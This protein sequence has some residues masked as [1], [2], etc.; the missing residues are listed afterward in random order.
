[1]RQQ[2]C[3]TTSTRNTGRSAAFTLVETSC[4]VGAL[5]IFV[6]AVIPSM[7]QL[8]GD[9]WAAVTRDHMRSY[10]T[11]HAAHIH[12]HGYLPPFALSDGYYPPGEPGNARATEVGLFDSPV[13]P[14]GSTSLI[15]LM[16]A[17]FEQYVHDPV[18]YTSP[19]DTL[20]RYSPVGGEDSF[21]GRFGY[22]LTPDED[23]RG[24]GA[25]FTRLWFTA[26]NWPPGYLTHNRT[27]V[28]EVDGLQEIREVS[29]QSIDRILSPADHVD[30]V[31]EDEMSRL[32]QSLFVPEQGAWAPPP[33][34]PGNSNVIARRHPND[35]GHVAYFDGHVRAIENVTERYW[36]EERED[37]RI[38]LLWPTVVVSGDW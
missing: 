18:I 23:P 15:T 16:S 27:V 28:V 37:K 2:R 11:A 35:S 8:R 22:F 13:A 24:V 19:A 20:E 1:M 14:I 7:A 3:T 25:T 32:D 21:G 17:F 9:D 34:D 33:F 38:H 36:N 12:D 5:G 4:C 30:L 26:G 6:C 31:E 29:S 10:A